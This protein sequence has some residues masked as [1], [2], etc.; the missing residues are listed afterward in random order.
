MRGGAACGRPGRRRDR[1]CPGRRKRGIVR[2]R[3]VRCRRLR[4]RRRRR[5]GRR[6]R[7]AVVAEVAV[8]AV[9]DGS[10]RSGTCRER[11]VEH[12]VVPQR[13]RHVL[14]PDRHRERRAG[15][16]LAVHVEHRDL[17]LRVAHP[18]DGRE[19]ARVAVEPGVGVVLGRA[20]SC[21][22][23]GGCRRRSRRPCRSAAFCCSTSFTFQATPC[24][25]DA[26]RL[27]L[28]PARVV[29]TLPLG[30]I[31]FVIAIGFA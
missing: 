7:R 20:R 11:E 6:R 13:R 2:R 16:R 25:S 9:H 1:L 18:D 27:R 29:S 19:L 4:G 23:S 14:V 22:R 30:R 3:R 24:E 15:D 12:L 31:T 8:V 21:R 5:G 10:S 26:L 28:A 17:A